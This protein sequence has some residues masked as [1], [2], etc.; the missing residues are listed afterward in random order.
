MPLLTVYCT[1]WRKIYLNN[2]VQ[3]TKNNIVSQQ[4]IYIAVCDFF[5]IFFQCRKHSSFHPS[6]HSSIQRVKL[7]LFKSFKLF[8]NQQNSDALDTA[9]YICAIRKPF[10]VIEWTNFWFDVSVSLPHKIHLQ[11]QTGKD[12]EKKLKPKFIPYIKQLCMYTVHCSTV[13]SIFHI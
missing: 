10:F 2:W 1:P 13:V 11:H 6:N 3:V 12:V 9:W 4:T 5:F 7:L 8:Y